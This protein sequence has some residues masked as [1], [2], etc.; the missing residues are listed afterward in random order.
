[1]DNMIVI[2]IVSFLVLIILV[3]IMLKAF[4]SRRKTKYTKMLE[5][6]EYEKN[7][8]ASSPVGPELAKVETYLKNDKLET[9][10]NEWQKR[11]DDINN[12][13]IP[14]ITDM[15]IDAEYTVSQKD[16]RNAM[17]KIAKLEMEVYKARTTSDVLLDEIKELTTSKERSRAI[18]TK[19][20]TRYRE[21]YEKFIDTKPEF[22]DMTDSVELQFENISRRFEDFEHSM[23]KN[24]YDEVHA[25][26][27]A[28][29]EMLNHIDVIIDEMPTVVL[30][31][32][33]ILPKKMEDIKNIFDKMTADG[34][35]LGY[36][37]VEFNIS[38]A[39]KKIKD[40]LDRAKVLD[41]EDSVF[42]LKVLSEYFESLFN[43]FDKEKI[44]KSE[45]N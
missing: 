43:D 30:L 36:L 4:K 9:R 23:D 26:L 21:L 11:L 38:E 22:G 7:Q 12:V 29:E 42:E 44:I 34:Y 3:L 40:I 15:I 14:K 24:E 45:Y 19:M 17:N 33:G 41:L 20:K 13:Q 16:Y 37:N 8:I 27:N 39:S 6:L 18:I 2:S 28:I 32:E 5:N 25:I 1:M 31:G 10:Y 35:S